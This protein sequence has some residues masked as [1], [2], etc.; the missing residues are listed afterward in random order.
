MSLGIDGIILN[1]IILPLNYIYCVSFVTIFFCPTTLFKKPSSFTDYL[2]GKKVSWLLQIT[3]LLEKLL[4][5]GKIVFC[6]YL[7]NVTI[8]DF[9]FQHSTRLAK[10]AQ[11][12]QNGFLLALIL[13]EVSHSY[14]QFTPP[15]TSTFSISGFHICTRLINCCSN[16]YNVRMWILGFIYLLS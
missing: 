10:V 5:S 8:P 2:L 15:C 14:I 12:D 16:F 7:E 1:Y 9:C 4:F 11:G 3:E 6:L 13:S